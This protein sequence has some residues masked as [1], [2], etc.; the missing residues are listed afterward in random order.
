MRHL[1]R[2]IR[3][4]MSMP[5]ESSARFQVAGRGANEIALVD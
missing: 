4:M 3:A 2:K 1:P 5:W